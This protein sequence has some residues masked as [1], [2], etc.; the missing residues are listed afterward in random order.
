MSADHVR[1]VMHN[2]FYG[3]NNKPYIIDS[4]SCDDGL[5]CNGK[6]TTYTAKGPELFDLATTPS[7][8]GIV[9]AYHGRRPLFRYEGYRNGFGFTQIIEILSANSF[10][11]VE[12]KCEAI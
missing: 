1:T 7:G 12:V 11:G 10:V 5:N 2:Q 3:S 9:Q 8:G 4:M 6:R